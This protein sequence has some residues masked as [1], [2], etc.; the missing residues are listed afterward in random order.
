MKS[1]VIFSAVA[2]FCAVFAAPLETSPNEA[3]QLFARKL[4]VAEEGIACYYDSNRC[5]WHEC[6][7]C[8]CDGVD[9]G[10]KL[11]RRD[12]TDAKDAA[13]CIYVSNLK[14]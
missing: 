5:Y 3:S 7:H 14:A 11:I 4:C 1:A 9:N 13:H 6:S 12:C 10:A 8:S 2:L